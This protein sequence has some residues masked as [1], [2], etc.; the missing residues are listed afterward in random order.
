MNG[1]LEVNNS[2]KL[3]KEDDIDNL[4]IIPKIRSQLKKA[5]IR[6]INDLCQQLD[7]ELLRIDDLGKKTLQ[8]IKDSLHEHGFQ[9]LMERDDYI[10][11]LNIPKNVYNSLIKHGIRTIEHLCT[12]KESELFELT[13]I[14]KED[15]KEIQLEL[16]N[17]NYAMLKENDLS[18]WNLNI[19]GRT[20]YILRCSGFESITDL[21]DKTDY[22]L[23]KHRLMGKIR[24]EEIRNAL[25]EAGYTTILDSP[26]YI[27]KLNLSAFSHNALVSVGIRYTDELLNK[28]ER[29]LLSYGKIGIACLDDIKQT[30]KKSDLC[31]PEEK[32]TSIR[33]LNISNSLCDT[34]ERN[35]IITI[36]D[37]CSSTRKTLL[38]IKK[39]GKEAINE[40][41]KALH[42]AGFRTAIEKTT[43]IE[44]LSIRKGTLKI[45]ES[46]NI[47]TV[48]DLCEK[49][50]RELIQFYEISPFCLNDI[51][52][53]LS[54]IGYSLAEEDFYYIEGLDLPKKIYHVLI[55]M[56]IY[57]IDQL[58][59]I[60]RSQLKKL[61]GMSNA[62]IYEI[63]LRLN[64]IGLCL[65]PEDQTCDENF[66]D[67]NLKEIYEFKKFLRRLDFQYNKELEEEADL[68]CYTEEEK[69]NSYSY[70][71]DADDEDYL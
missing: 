15:I 37:L 24:I 54:E 68:Y 53:A 59:K 64:N 1:V 58:C 19:T 27:G 71:Y 21:L 18:L 66:F 4:D 52:N 9:T 45:L 16:N 30:L 11:K 43:N 29:E 14:E 26:N 44:K 41:E 47:T 40:L 34:L 32:P 55:N 28:T 65:L 20:Y 56:D 36:N 63:E 50:E 51:K 46:E 31:L 69:E 49:T 6:T 3:N 62:N 7:K 38:Q 2:S 25:A 70:F 39:V 33:N 60:K 48:E 42:D 12:F 23:M 8:D 67:K 10:G 22:E 17:L 13:S 57:T 5:G 35:N 61:Y